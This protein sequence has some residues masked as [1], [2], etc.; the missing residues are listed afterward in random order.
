MTN[1]LLLGF[2]A[3]TKEERKGSPVSSWAVETQSKKGEIFLHNEGLQVLRYGYKELFDCLG[4]TAA[5][6]YSRMGANTR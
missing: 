2:M 4:N 5:V 1:A 3:A 6:G